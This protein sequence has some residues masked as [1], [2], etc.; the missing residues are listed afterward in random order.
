MSSP[1]QIEHLVFTDVKISAQPNASLDA[2]METNVEFNGNVSK[3]DHRNWMLTVRVTLKNVGD[4]VSPDIREMMQ[5]GSTQAV[6]AILQAGDTHNAELRE[7]LR[8]NGVKV[9]QRLGDALVVE[10]PLNVVEKVAA[11]IEKQTDRK[12]ELRSTIDE[13]IVGGIVLQVGDK[14]LDASIR[15]RLEKLRKNVAAAA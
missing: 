12:V 3:D 13:D 4:K 6:S 5:G 9:S 11:E 15:N 10:L 2:S 14:V 8:A 1:L 7:L